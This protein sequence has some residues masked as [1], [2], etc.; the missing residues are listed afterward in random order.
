M[1][2]VASR[3]WQIEADQ[4]HDIWFRYA[5]WRVQACNEIGYLIERYELRCMWIVSEIRKTTFKTI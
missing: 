2:F 1:Y 4:S 5:Q 3:N